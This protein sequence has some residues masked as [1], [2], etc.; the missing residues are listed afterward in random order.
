MNWRAGEAFAIPEFFLGDRQLH[1]R[2]S[3]A[4]ELLARVVIA[5][6]GT[7]TTTSLAETVG[8]SPRT[9]RALLGNLHQSGLLRQHD[10]TRDAWS[11]VS[12]LGD[13][14]LADVFRSVAGAEAEASRRR[15]PEPQSAGE[16]RSASQQNVDLLL[17]QATMAVN[18]L[19]MQHLQAFDLGR[20]KAVKSS[21]AFYSSSTSARSYIAEPL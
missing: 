2:F 1:E 10:K 8:C 18:Q 4:I 9:V 14:T 11:C 7:V 16:S 5:N 15:Q 20:L 21:G 6:P 12:A 19:V 13:I 17:M 3:M